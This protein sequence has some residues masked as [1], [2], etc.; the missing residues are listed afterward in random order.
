MSCSLIENVYETS[1]HYAS[2]A[3]G[4]WGV[5]KIAQLIPES[6][7][8]FVSP[9]ACG[10]HGALGA[11]MEGRKD[12]VSYLFLTEQSIVSGD[13]EQMLIDALDK[14]MDFLGKR[15]RIPKVMGVFV[16]CIDDLLGTDHEALRQELED[17]YKGIKFIDCHMNPTSSDTGVPP[18]VNVQNKIYSVLE[19]S[20]VSDDGVNIVGNLEPIHKESELYEVLTKMGATAIRHISDYKTYDAYQEMASS[21]L[22]IRLAPSVKYACTNMERKLGI[23]SVEAL[24]A[25]RPENIRKN[26]ELI[27]NELGVDC[28]ELSEYEKEAEEALLKAQKD[29]GDM[30]LILDWEC[31][32]RVFEFARCLLE[33]GFSVRRIYS[34]QV[35]PSDKENFEWVCENYPDIEI[36]QPQNPRTTFVDAPEDECIAIGYSAGYLSGAK[37]VVDIG[38]QNGLY[39]YRGLKELLNKVRKA[40]KEEADLKKILEDAVIIV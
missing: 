16:S 35:I 30:P 7:F 20:E 1:L 4:G 34:Q 24:I 25:Y 32:I 2:P 23:P 33:N 10:R 14:L 21:R 19:R 11:R 6:Y 17:R 8:I 29:I 3:H 22:N 26:Y 12:T 15:D 37:H 36:L 40:K 13:Y 5:L 31:I 18:L 9:A 27:A 38:G 28:P 39:G